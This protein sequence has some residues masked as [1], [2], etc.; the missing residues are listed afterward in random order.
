MGLQLAGQ[1][2]GTDFKFPAALITQKYLNDNGITNMDQLRV[3][4]PELA[5]A[6]QMI[7]CWI[8]VAY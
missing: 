2:T 4:M 1:L 5:E 8:Q 7:G 3:A 6:S